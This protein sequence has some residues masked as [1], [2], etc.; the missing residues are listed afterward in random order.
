MKSESGNPQQELGAFLRS[1]RARLTPDRVGLP[2]G[3][4]R[5]T[6][7]LRREEVAQLAAVSVTWYTWLEQGRKVQPSTRALDRIARVLRLNDV[8]RAHLFALAQLPTTALGPPTPPALTPALR[9]MLDSQMNP[10]YLQ[11]ARW[12]VLAWS[13]ALRAVFGDLEDV[14]DHE[15]NMLWLVFTHSDYRLMMPDWETDA[16]AMVAKFRVEF[17]RHSQDPAFHDLVEALSLR[18]ADFRSWWSEQDV[19]DL[20]EGHKRFHHGRAG[21]IQFE[22]TTFVVENAPDLR[23]VVYTPL[24]GESAR[25]VAELVLHTDS[26]PAH[27]PRHT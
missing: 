12:D 18:S 20:G 4:R 27:P 17:G 15:R 9:R 11:T 22:H 23:L 1:R 3:A 26:C 13:P 16:R 25:K 7:G 24:A 5:R 10:S 14:P 19:L 2:V 21:E 8:E 6:P